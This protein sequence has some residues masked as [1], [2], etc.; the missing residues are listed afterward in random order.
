MD[1]VLIAGVGSTPYGKHEDASSRELLVEASSKAF[2]D[3]DVTTDVVDAV[4]VGNFMGDITDDQ[5]HM[6]ALAADYLGMPRAASMRIESACASSGAATYVARQAIAHGQT[7]VALVAGVE[8]MFATGI[9]EITDALANAADN[10]Y[11]NAV[12]LTFPA[13]YALMMREYLDRTDA[14]ME[15]LAAI[16]MKNRDNGVANPLSQFQKAA[17]LEE[18]QTARPIADPINLLHACPITDG[19]SAAILVSESFASE[20]DLDASVTITGGGFA[21]DTLALQDRRALAR[22]RAAEQAAAE[23]FS[24]SGRSI[25]DVDVLE[26]HDC[27]TIAEVLA[28]ESLG[29]YDRGEGWRGA[30]EGET[31]L[32]GSLPVNTSGGLISKGHPVG[33]TGIGQIA[34]ITK[35][36]EGRHPNQVD[37]ATLGV[38]HN[39]GGSGASAVVH[40]MEVII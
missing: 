35:Q 8:N 3:A 28:L 20:H 1:R 30:A 16:T 37:D 22:T 13:I 19:A 10:E 17:E 6:G 12:G 9:A 18:I 29:V 24:E 14:T 11:E 36:L 25:G 33:A 38:T 34:E 39:V 23:A 15:D 31:H 27:F 2:D 7:D 26:V 4:Y 21:S 5:G 40:V 32:D